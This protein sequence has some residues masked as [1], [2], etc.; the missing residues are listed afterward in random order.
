MTWYITREAVKDALDIKATARSDAQIDRCIATATDQITGLLRRQFDPLSATLRFPAPAG[1]TL[2]FGRRSLVSVTSVS[3]DGVALDDADYLL[4]PLDDGPPYDGIRIVATSTAS[5][6]GGEDPA[7]SITGVWGYD[8]TE[9]TAGATAEALDA[10]ETSVDLNGE[11]SAAV[12]VGSVIRVDSERMTVTA[13]SLL[14]TGVTLSANLTAA[15]ADT[16]VTVSSGAGVTV[17]ETVLIDAEYMKVH[18]V[19]GNVLLVT[20]AVDGSTLATHTSGATLYAPRTVTVTRGALGTTAATHTDASVVRVWQP[21]PLV[22]E[23]ALAYALTSL[24]QSQAGYAR[25]VGSNENEREASGR[26]LKQIQEHAMR[27]Y[28]RWLTGAV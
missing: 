7:V 14:S 22:G 16:A 11:A 3:V 23:L 4:L 15:K 24:G 13:R 5:L 2:W 28:K 19:A 20:R 9:I 6:F 25:T 17:G 21:P 10:A 26:G 12:G 1:Q 18:A 8:L 27:E